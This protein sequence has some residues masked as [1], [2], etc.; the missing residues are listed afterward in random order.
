MYMVNGCTAGWLVG[1]LV[2]GPAAVV[3]GCLTLQVSRP[4]V[5]THFSHE[6]NHHRNDHMAGS[7]PANECGS[8]RRMVAAPMGVLCPWDS[9]VESSEPL[10]VELGKVPVWSKSKYF[11]AR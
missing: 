11:G 6:P 10:R 9:L 1:W 2:G 7:R 4:R 8:M 5:W 3:V